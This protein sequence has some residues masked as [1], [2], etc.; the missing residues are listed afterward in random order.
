MLY[1]YIES[2]FILDY[3]Q[4]LANRLNSTVVFPRHPGAREWVPLP[5]THHIFCQED[6]DQAEKNKHFHQNSHR[7]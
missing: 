3:K 1:K 4:D 5:V 6:N 2:K 7:S